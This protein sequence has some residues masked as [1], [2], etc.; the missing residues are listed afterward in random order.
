MRVLIIGDIVGRPGRKAVNLLN[1]ILRDEHKF[2]LLFANE[3]N[4]AG[5][6]EISV[7]T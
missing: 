7:D 4:A 1:P 6:K 3:E 2:D 5:G